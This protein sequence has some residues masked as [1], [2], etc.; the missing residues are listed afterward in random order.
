MDM[1]AAAELRNANLGDRRLN[2]RL[3]RIVETLAAQPSASVPQACGNW[4]D[5]KAVYRFW[6]D[7]QVDP[8][9]IRDGHRLSTL[10][11]VVSEGVVLLI[12]DTTELDFA[13]HPATRGLGPLEHAAQLGMKVH[14]VLA[15]ST[16]GVPLGLI[17]Q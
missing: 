4:A 1:W 9:A 14:S 11:R 15:V 2:R 8:Q 3:V 7:E 6:D 10:E 5:T 17:H 16:D 12:Q 13:H